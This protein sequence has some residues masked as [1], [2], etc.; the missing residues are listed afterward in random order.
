MA[1]WA[2]A[3][4]GSTA[5]GYDG[6]SCE[7]PTTATSGWAHRR[8]AADVGVAYD[9]C[10]RA[11]LRRRRAV[12]RH[13]ARPRRQAGTG[14]PA[15]HV[16]GVRGAG[17]AQ[18]RR[19]RRRAAR[20]LAATGRV[21]LLH[22][23]GRIERRRVSVVVVVGRRIGPRRSRPL[24]IA[25]DALKASRRSGSTRTGTDGADWGTGAHRSR[26]PATVRGVPPAD[27]RPACRSSSPSSSSR[28]S[29]C[30]SP[31]WL[32]GCPGRGRIR[33]SSASAGTSTRCRRRR[34]R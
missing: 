22:R 33:A 27:A 28:S 25:I 8:R 16:R 7:H 26:W 11:R 23:T 10:V 32:G 1:R 9:W 12:Q 13:R 21:V 15:P 18:A 2:S 20:P 6:P 19:D 4:R 31:S 14:R 29:P 3:G 5:D 17:R 34:G 24:A 30:S